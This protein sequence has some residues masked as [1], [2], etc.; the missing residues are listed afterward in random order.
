MALE[1]TKGTDVYLMV[2]VGSEAWRKVGGQKDATF[3][4][5]VGTMDI[6]NKNSAGDEEHL[7]G[8]KNW[9]ISFDALLIEDDEGWL[10]IEAA[11]DAGTQLPYKFVTPGFDYKGKATVEALSISAPDADASVASLT[12]KGTGALTKTAN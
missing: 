7:I 6:T 10:A 11:Y 2:D 4:R 1:K 12:L 3:D 8:N 5:G 9:G